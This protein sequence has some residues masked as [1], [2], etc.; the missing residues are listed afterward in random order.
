M[1]GV[2][3]RSHHHHVRTSIIKTFGSYHRLLHTHYFL[4]LL[5]RTNRRSR[6][7]SSESPRSPR[8]RA[9]DRCAALAAA[10]ASS[11]RSASRC[12]PPRTRPRRPASSPHAP[13]ELVLPKDG[14]LLPAAP[15]ARQG[16]RVLDLVFPPHARC[17]AAAVRAAAPSQRRVAA[18]GAEHP[19]GLR[20]DVVAGVAPEHPAPQL[21]DAHAARGWCFAQTPC[22]STFCIE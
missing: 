14:R 5:V 12:T 18:L 22:R 4:R 21:G 13:D 9:D 3:S 15:W 2:I 19:R 20:A 7:S 11:P 16:A 8:G 10:C 6:G 17:S 1:C